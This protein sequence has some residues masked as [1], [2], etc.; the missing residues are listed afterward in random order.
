VSAQVGS[1]SEQIEDSKETQGP[2]FFGEFLVA[3]GVISGEALGEALDELERLNPK[4]CD[5]AVERGF[6]SRQQSGYLLEIQRGS[7]LRVGELAIQLGFMTRSQVTQLV[8]TQ[9]S[10]R[11]MLGELLV[12]QGLLYESQLEQSLARFGEAHKQSFADRC[13]ADYATVPL[14]GFLVDALPYSLTRISGSRVRCSQASPWLG[15]GSPYAHSARV[16]LSGAVALEL[17]LAVDDEFGRRLVEMVPSS[18]QEWPCS[19]RI[20]GFLERFVAEIIARH[21]EYGG[22]IVG[23]SARSSLPEGGLVY[24]LKSPVGSGILVVHAPLAISAAA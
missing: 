16:S 23:E 20:A 21:A 24:S 4:I 6:L 5:L 15:D 8:R 1:M 18:H 12:M 19:V 3:D 14:L 2:G 10:S 9:E 7:E 11:I 22:T 17:G 13:I